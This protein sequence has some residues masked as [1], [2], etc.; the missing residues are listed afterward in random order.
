MVLLHCGSY[1]QDLTLNAH[2]PVDGDRFW[3]FD[4]KSSSSVVGDLLGHTVKPWS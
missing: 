1:L 2:L 3:R 4:A